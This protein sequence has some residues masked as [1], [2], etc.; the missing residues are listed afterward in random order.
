MESNPKL[1]AADAAYREA[2]KKVYR[3]VEVAEEQ[4]RIAI[5]NLRAALDREMDGQLTAAR[6]WQ[7]AYLDEVGWQ[8]RAKAEPPG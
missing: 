1:D 7:Q 2:Y 4:V 3:E 8:S 5:K 6:A